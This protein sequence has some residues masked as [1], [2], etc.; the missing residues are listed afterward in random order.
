ML[1]C[2]RQCVVRCVPQHNLQREATALR[3]TSERGDSASAGIGSF[4]FAS[5]VSSSNPAPALL[6]GFSSPGALA[7]TPHGT[8]PPA[9][10]CLAYCS[11]ARRRCAA[12]CSS[13]SCCLFASAA[14]SLAFSRSISS[15]ISRV[16]RRATSI[17]TAARPSQYSTTSLPAWCSTFCGQFSSVNAM[18]SI[19]TSCC[20]CS[21]LLAIM[22]LSSSILF[23]NGYST[24]HSSPSARRTHL[25]LDPL[26][27][28]RDGLTCRRLRVWSSRD[29]LQCPHAARRFASS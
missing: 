28:S 8:R 7:S 24:R 2:T 6:H 29:R 26:H 14:A 17:V 5:H 18:S 16:M 25:Q 9:A 27:H 3:Q 19:G 15:R 1:D 23:R 13:N 22:I 20:G 4:E 21:L 12:T 10:T 11:S